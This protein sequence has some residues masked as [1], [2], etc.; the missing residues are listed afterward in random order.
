MATLT[1]IDYEV[2]QQQ[3][4]RGVVRAALEQTIVHG[5]PGDHHFYISFLTQSPGV[6]ISKVLRERYPHE[7]TIVLQHRFWDLIVSEDRFEVK[8]SFDGVPE[9]LVVPFASIKVFIDPSVRYGLQFDDAGQ[10]RRPAMAPRQSLTFDAA[11]DQVGEAR[12][13]GG[14]V[15]T[16]ANTQKKTRLPRKSKSEKDAVVETTVPAISPAP[17]KSAP[18]PQPASAAAPALAAVES[19]GEERGKVV[20]LDQFRKR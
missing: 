3:A 4:L 18:T 8:L 6:S 17:P 5:L 1:S 7:M 20:S 15:G 13:D 10:D 16:S 12:L 14:H 9:R 11:Y 19:D 2:M